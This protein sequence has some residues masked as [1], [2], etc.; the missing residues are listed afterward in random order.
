MTQGSKFPIVPPLEDLE[1]AFHKK[2][3]K[4]AG[5][6]SNTFQTDKFEGFEKTHD[7]K[8]IGYESESNTGDALEDNIKS[9]LDKMTDDYGG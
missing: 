1:S 8:G 2:K 6:S 9:E 7:K 5:E 3:D 4:K